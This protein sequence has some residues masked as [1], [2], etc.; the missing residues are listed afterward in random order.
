MVKNWMML[1]DEA[2]NSNH[3]PI[4]VIELSPEELDNWQ[5]IAWKRFAGVV[6]NNE[7]VRSLV[8]SSNFLYLGAT[9][10]KSSGVTKENVDDFADSLFQNID[11][12]EYYTVDFSVN[13]RTDDGTL[14]LAF[15][16]YSEEKLQKLMPTYYTYI[17]GDMIVPVDCQGSDIFS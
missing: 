17:K 6:N 1:G 14:I 8:F 7:K 11:D 3:E 15:G 13:P 9:F 12:L 4:G 5:K 16:M 10:S 2:F